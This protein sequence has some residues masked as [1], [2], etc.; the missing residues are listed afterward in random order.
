MSGPGVLE[1]SGAQLSA[2]RILVTEAAYFSLEES[3]NQMKISGKGLHLALFASCRQFL[4]QIDDTSP[5]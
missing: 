3:H 1:E 4:D 2:S 5:S